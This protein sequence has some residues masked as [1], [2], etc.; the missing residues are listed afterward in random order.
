MRDGT[1]TSIKRDECAILEDSRLDGRLIDLE[2]TTWSVEFQTS[3]I[4]PR[5]KVDL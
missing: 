4:G 5:G 3:E 2:P 1:L